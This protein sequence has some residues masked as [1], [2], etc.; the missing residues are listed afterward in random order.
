VNLDPVGGAVVANNPVRG[1]AHLAQGN[2]CPQLRSF[3]VYSLLPPDFGI[4]RGDERYSSGVK[5]ADYASISQDAASSGTLHYRIVADGVS[6]HY[7]RDNGTPCDFAL[8]GSAS[9][10]QRIREVSTYFS[11]TSETGCNDVAGSVG[12]PVDGRDIKTRTTLADFA[13]NPLISGA[14]GH[15]QFTMKG[16]GKASIDVFDIEGRLVKS[17]YSGLAKEGVNDAFWNGTGNDG[18]Q[19]ASGVFFYRLRTS[20]GD[21]LSKKMVVV[22]NGGK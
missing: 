9:V 13:P 10:T 5:S 15:I 17:I 16:E 20:L 18:R 14:A 11:A 21:D 12:I 1:V 7:R 2:G 4:S 3:D 8:G 22:S 6:V 19:V